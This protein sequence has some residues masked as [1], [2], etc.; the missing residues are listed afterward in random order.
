MSLLTLSE[1]S[2]HFVADLELL[3]SAAPSGTTDG[4]RRIQRICGGVSISSLR[5][6][7]LL[8]RNTGVGWAALG[9]SVRTRGRAKGFIW[10]CQ[11]AVDMTR[12]R[13]AGVE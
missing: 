1:I 13:V 7:C 2:Y 4:K 12:A 9:C 11:Q 3:S 8:S 5:V 6:S 10:L